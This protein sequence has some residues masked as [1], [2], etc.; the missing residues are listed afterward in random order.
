MA[1]VIVKRV[2]TR[3]IPAIESIS[4]NLDTTKETFV[5]NNHVNVSDYFQG[6]FVVKISGTPT[7]PGTAVPVYF[8]TEGVLD[9]DIQL[10]DVIGNEVTTAIF[11][12]GVYLCFYDRSTNKLRLMSLPIV[13]STP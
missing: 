12:D 1:N 8:K 6:F 9:S 4:V 13:T 11:K 7:A 5:F 3:G 2:N 10:F